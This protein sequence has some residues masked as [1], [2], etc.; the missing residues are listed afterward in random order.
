[1]MQHF[2][3]K[4][5]LDKDC[6]KSVAR[7]EYQKHKTESDALIYETYYITKYSPKYNKLGQSRDKPTIELHD[8]KWKTYQVLK[9]N[10]KYYKT[11]KNTFTL[12]LKL[13]LIIS[14]IYSIIQVFL[15]DK[16]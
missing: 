3:S 12:I 7:I 5:H 10:T 13:I 8:E 14:L 15:G 2:S 16:I 6:Y 11:K 1:M 9:E 4:G